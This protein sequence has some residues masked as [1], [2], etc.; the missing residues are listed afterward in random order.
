MNP[1]NHNDG[2]VEYINF[3]LQIPPPSPDTLK[4]ANCVGLKTKLVMKFDG[5]AL[6]VGVDGVDGDSN[7]IGNCNKVAS[8]I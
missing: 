7:N 5:V 4:R 3:H 1:L 2:Q 6:R 8:S